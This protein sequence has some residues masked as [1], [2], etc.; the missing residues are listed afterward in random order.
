MATLRWQGGTASQRQVA[1]LTPSTGSGTGTEVGDVFNVI[2]TAEDG[3]TTQT[4]AVTCTGTT[5]A[6]VCDDIVAQ[7][8]ASTQTMFQKVTFVDSTSH[9]TVSARV[10]GVPFYLS[11][12]VANTDG[13]GNAPAFAAA[14]TTA[15]AGPND[16]NTLA[17]WVESDG[18]APSA[19]P[20]SGDTVL[21]SGGNFDALYGLDQNAVDLDQMKVG[22]GYSGNIGGG[23][24]ALKI[25]VSNTGSNN[26]PFLALGGS[27]R[28]IN[29]EGT[30]DN[31]LITRNFGDIDIKGTSIRHM[32]IIGSQATGRVTVKDSS[33]FDNSIGVFRQLAVG[34]GAYTRIGSSITGL[35]Q[36][37]MDSGLIECKSTVG[38]SN[39]DELAI[40]AGRFIAAGNMTTRTTRVFGGELLWESDADFGT[41]TAG[42]LE[43]YGGTVDVSRNKKVG[44][45]TINSATIFGGTLDMSSAEKVAFAGADSRTNA[46]V[47]AGRVIHSNVAATVTGDGEY[48]SSHST[49]T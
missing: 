30:F 40:H 7:C 13:D 4:E 27:G 12:T 34:P 16:W 41:N 24:Y 48:D 10:P 18:T 47:Y 14:V 32:Q 22:A 42:P 44:T 3:T 11:E 19:V 26:T 28:R 39:A 20:A 46:V 25:S 1:T 33:T 38:L 8:N 35:K 29:V 2:L 49:L 15:N 36:L 6:S 9:V 31:I 17:N 37:R 5:V 23:S 43:I 45:L 21:F